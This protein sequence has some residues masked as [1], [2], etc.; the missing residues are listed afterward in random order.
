MLSSG[1]AILGCSI[2]LVKK[3]NQEIDEIIETTELY[4]TA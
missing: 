4:G 3:G 1:M 2:K